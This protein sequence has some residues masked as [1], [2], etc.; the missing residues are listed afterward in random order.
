[1]AEDVVEVQ[2]QII[3][4]EKDVL[5]K[6]SEAIGGKGEQNIDLSWIKD[7]ISS[8]QQ[9][10]AQGNHDKVFY[11]ACG[12]DILRTMV[13]YDATEISA[14]DTDETLVPRIATQFEEAGIPLSI[15][16]IDEITQE[17]TC[18]YEEKPRTI[19]FQKTDARLV[20]SEL[21]P[22]SVDVLHIFLPTGAESK[23]SED[24][25][26]RVANSLTLE[27]YQLVSTGGFM[28]F[29]ERS[30]TPLGE[31]P[32]ALLKIAGIE[33]QKITRRQ[34]N[35]V[36]TSFYPTPDQIS[37]MDRTGYIY[38]KTENVG[39]DLM[40]DM[41]QGLDHRLTSDYVFMEVARGGYDYLN[42]EEGNTDMGVALT[43]FTK[44]EDKQVDVVAESM[45]LHG[46]ISENVQAYKSEQKAISR[47]QLQKIQEQY[48][49]FLGAYQEVVIKLKAKTIDNTQA[50]EELGIVQGEYGK[51]SRKWPIA[52]AYVQDTE[53]NGIKTREAVQQL[54][55]L[56]LTGL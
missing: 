9:A 52:L 44:D 16:E 4:K 34:P 15:N 53:K 19:K 37:R 35:T 47:R 24:E 46:V 56:D 6:V 49:E 10:T 48:K 11:P 45:T 21:A 5:P 50:L 54:A 23:I 39:N 13:A 27:N 42:A 7:N 22:G 2:T 18:T 43:N 51:E 38:H 17:L 20:I 32:S 12:T 30:L 40:N 41:L 8:I 26:S 55:N 31:T 29:D 28:V 25:G 1:M 33:E 36:L 14:V 3:Q